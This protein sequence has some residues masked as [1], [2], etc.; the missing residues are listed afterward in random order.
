MKLVDGAPSAAVDERQIG[1]SAIDV[2][3]HGGGRGNPKRVVEVMN[4]GVGVR[5]VA[6]GVAARGVVTKRQVVPRACSQLPVGVSVV[7]EASGRGAVAGGAGGG[8]A[9]A[10]ATGAGN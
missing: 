8:A 9:V 6:G 7:G 4:I 10:D 2:V 5:L 1:A 3:N